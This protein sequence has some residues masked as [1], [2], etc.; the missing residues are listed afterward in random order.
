MLRRRALLHLQPLLLLVLGQRQ[1]F[2]IL[3]ILLFWR[4]AVSASCICRIL[5][6]RDRGFGGTTGACC[7]RR[8]SAAICNFCCFWLRHWH[9]DGCYRSWRLYV[10]RRLCCLDREGGRLL[11]LRWDC[12]GGSTV[13]RHQSTGGAPL[14][15]CVAQY[16]ASADWF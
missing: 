7:W 3:S 13:V 1:R 2:P 5:R 16:A 15:A 4:S 9:I 12:G 10:V 8:L 11:W 14:C 6:R